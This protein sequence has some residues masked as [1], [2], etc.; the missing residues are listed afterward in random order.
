MN[1][2]NEVPVLLD[3]EGGY[4]VGQKTKPTVAIKEETDECYGYAA[5]RAVKEES[6]EEY[7]DHLAIK[8]E[9]YEYNDR[10]I[11]QEYDE[12]YDHIK[13]EFGDAYCMDYYETLEQDESYNDSPEQLHPVGEGKTP[14]E[15]STKQPAQ[16]SNKDLPRSIKT[17]VG[18]PPTLLRMTTEIVASNIEKYQ[19]SVFSI[20]SE[21]QWES[22]AE[23][24]CETYHK[25]E[26]SIHNRIKLLMPPVSA[27]K[28]M[29]I[30]SHPAN[31][32]LCQ[33][34]KIDIL[35]WKKIVNYSFPKKGITRPPV[36]EEP[37]EVLV[38]RLK[39]WG[40]NLV[41][42][43]EWKEKIGETVPDQSNDLISRR[44]SDETQDSDEEDVKESNCTNN[45][46][47]QE[48]LL[49][50]QSRTGTR[51]LA[52]FLM[53]IQNSP[54]DVHLLSVSGIGKCVSKVVKIGTKL[55]KQ[56]EQNG[57]EGDKLFEALNGYP[58]F[59]TASY[60][61]TRY[62]NSNPYTLFTMHTHEELDK[63]YKIVTLLQLLQQLLREWKDMASANGVAISSTTPTT[64]PPTKKHKTDST[65]ASKADGIQ[66]PFST[67]GKPRNSDA[68][69]HQTDIKL[70]HSS[71][72][73]KALYHSL[74]KR[75]TMVREA[76]GEKVRASRES[77]EKN[78]AKVG[79]VK[80]KKAVGRVR[81]LSSPG[82]S[83]AT[84]QDRREAIL[85]KSLG[86][87]AQIK[88]AVAS[89][90][91][92]SRSTSKLSQLRQESKVQAKWSKG[93]KAAVSKISHTSSTPLSGFGAAV[94]CAGRT[95]TKNPPKMI[96]N[97]ARVDLQGGKR[98]TLPAA[99]SSKSVSMFTSLRKGGD[100]KK[101]AGERISLAK[102]GK[103]KK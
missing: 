93:T 66:I 35:L 39:E 70:L 87:R 80:L 24:R 85:N 43:F 73:W 62:G 67:F 56:M 65:N 64:S 33:S 52:T 40:E 44:K 71:S 37:C 48:E 60:K 18:P 32:H 30:E 11:K 23:C 79:Q 53:N 2:D 100:K 5:N 91:G 3:L 69:Q 17:I 46:P 75:E 63:E 68:D 6:D 58:H 36:L 76:H 77:L 83:F 19:P 94:A 95:I 86:M 34:P 42:L 4:V 90:S 10:A 25:L 31:V 14:D 21:C 81:G 29:R 74:Q 38:N 50:T 12:G 8:E 97:Q 57:V 49:S 72:N 45:A 61:L 88:Q 59:W 16:A 13:E 82:A 51:T 96:G 27:K 101:S 103:R 89:S 26:S 22:I 102:T 28:L 1:N 78:R 84:G 98:M 7:K 20:L 99:A 92:N 55:L 54:M 15:T 41:E 9:P 47:S